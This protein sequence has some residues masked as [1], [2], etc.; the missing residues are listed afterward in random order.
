[1]DI[2]QWNAN[3]IYFWGSEEIG[4]ESSMELKTLS[5]LKTSQELLSRNSSEFQWIAG[6]TKS[7]D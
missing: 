3:L 5:L 4:M 7:S 2:F 1:M 6:K